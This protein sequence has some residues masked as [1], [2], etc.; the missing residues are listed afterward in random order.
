MRWLW[1]PLDSDLFFA[2]TEDG[3]VLAWGW[4]QGAPFFG[5]ATKAVQDEA[6]LD[7]QKVSPHVSPSGRIVGGLEAMFGAKENMD[8]NGKTGNGGKITSQSIV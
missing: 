5:L 3:Q 6:V 2:R 8:K 1:G 7:V 4:G